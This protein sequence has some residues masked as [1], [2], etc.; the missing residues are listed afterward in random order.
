MNKFKS[1]FTTI[2]NR[3][4]FASIATLLCLIFATIGIDPITL[5]TWNDFWV[6]IVT[7]FSNPYKI[8]LVIGAVWGWYRNNQQSLSDI[9]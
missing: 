3:I 9:K 2:E 7:L 6:A 1:L 4:D 5:Q 8:V